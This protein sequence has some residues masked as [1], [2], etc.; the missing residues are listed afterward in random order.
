LRAI[1]L[2]GLLLS[3]VAIGPAAGADGLPGLRTMI[4]EVP[5]GDRAIDVVLWYP[6]A[7]GGTPVRVGDSPVFEG[8]EAQQDAPIAAGRF[9]IVLVSHGGMRAAPN[10]SNWIGSR[11]AGT[12]FVAAVVRGPA[13]GPRDAG[14]AVPETWRRPADLS[15][16]LSAL[17]GDPEWSGHL[18]RERVGA[19]GFFLGGTAALSLVG[20]RLD[21]ERFGASCDDGTGIDCRW[22][23]AAGVDLRSVDAESLTRSNLDPRIRVAVA[24]DPE[25]ASSFSPESLAGIEVPVEIINLGEP[26]TIQLG[27]R[28]AEL[29]SAIPGAKY[30]ALAG[31]SAFS[32][33]G[34]C[35]PQG[36]DIL[37]EEGESD[38][39]CLEASGQD[40]EALHAR[41]AELIVDG[42]AVLRATP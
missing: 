41:L 11:L 14:L 32:A 36:R 23:A 7:A 9:P 17:E 26:E 35:K 40:R 29:A 6:A 38:A 28:A 34:V 20:A 2:V 30:Q 31:A 5:G 13:L 16:A 24:V 19:V 42:L 27:F 39:M 4:V 15:A 21:A 37:K 33:L 3:A 18:D 8:V 22:F 1:A 12:G 25:L 10:H